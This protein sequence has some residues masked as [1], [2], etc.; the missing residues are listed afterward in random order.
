MSDNV[1]RKNTCPNPKWIKGIYS[2]RDFVR[3]GIFP[4]GIL[5]GGEL[6]NAQ[7]T[8]HQSFLIQQ[9]RIFISEISILRLVN[10]KIN[11]QRSDFLLDN[12]STCRLRFTNNYWHNKSVY[13]YKKYTT[14]PLVNLKINLQQSV[15]A[16]H[17]DRR[18]NGLAITSVGINN[19]RSHVK[20]CASSYRRTQSLAVWVPGTAQGGS[21]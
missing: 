10:F 16:W 4:E 12:W 6:V 20:P 17:Y 2:G 13:S 3:R 7:T 5:S 11:L 1:S 9:I 21:H 15:F 19:L 14:L 8:L 18:S